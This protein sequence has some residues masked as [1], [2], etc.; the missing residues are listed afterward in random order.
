MKTTVLCCLFVFTTSIFVACNHTD[1]DPNPTTVKM[2][3]LRLVTAEYEKIIQNEDSVKQELIDVTYISFAR[4]CDANRKQFKNINRIQIGD[5]VIVPA[6]K[7]FSVMIRAKKGDCL[8]SITKQAREL[9]SG[10]S[11]SNN[12]PLVAFVNE[13]FFPKTEKPFNWGLSFSLI[14]FAIACLSI[15]MSVRSTRQNYLLKKQLREA[16]EEKRRLAGI[17]GDE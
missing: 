16:E 15:F 12:K 4:T 17:T 9:F 5:M 1:I 10:T 8:W 7:D 3:P 2:I 14:A 11:I 13:D 6:G